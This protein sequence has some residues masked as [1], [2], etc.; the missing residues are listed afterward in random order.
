V[1]P[2]V[3]NEDEE[4]TDWN[5]YPRDSCYFCRDECDV[6]ETHHIVPR[7]HGGGDED[8]N[9]VDLCPTCHE[10]LERLYDKRFYEAVGVGDPDQVVS[11]V[12]QFLISEIQE[13]ELNIGQRLFDCRSRLEATH[14]TD[15]DDVDYSLDEHI[16]ASIQEYHAD[17]TPIDPDEDERS[18]KIR[19]QIK[20]IIHKIETKEGARYEQVIEHLNCKD[21]TSEKAEHEIEV[22]K[23]RGEVYEPK[24]G[25]LRTT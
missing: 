14:I 6:L 11:Y 3:Q 22:L 10:K 4:T 5:G 2:F 20:E 13:L 23:Q 18:K 24:Q 1:D 19:S 21:V 7:R 8:H 16:K 9:L 15:D 17:P 25:Y 12:T